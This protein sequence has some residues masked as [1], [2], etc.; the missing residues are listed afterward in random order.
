VDNH[1]NGDPKGRDPCQVAV[2]LRRKKVDLH[3]FRI[4]P[5][6]DAMWKLIK[7]AYDKGSHSAFGQPK[8]CLH[9]HE[10]PRGEGT[11]TER[12]VALVLDTINRSLS[13]SSI[14]SLTG[15]NWVGRAATASA[16]KSRFRPSLSAVLLG[17]EEAAGAGASAGAG[18]STAAPWGAQ[19]TAEIYTVHSAG[20]AVGADT[21]RMQKAPFAE[22]AMRAAFWMDPSGCGPLGGGRMVAKEGKRT[23]A[24]HNSKEALLG[25]LDSQLTAERLAE[26]WNRT[27]APRLGVP[28]SV[29][30]LPGFVMHFSERKRTDERWIAAERALPNNGADFRKFNNNGGFVDVADEAALANAFS[31]WTWQVTGGEAMVLD[32]Q[33]VNLPEGIVCTDAQVQCPD[34]TRYGRGN[35]GQQGIADFFAAHRCGPE[36]RQLRLRLPGEI[37]TASAAAEELETV[38]GAVLNGELVPEAVRIVSEERSQPRAAG[39]TTWQ[40]AGGQPIARPQ[41]VPDSDVFRCQ[42]STAPFCRKRGGIEFGLLWNRRH[43]CRACGVVVCSYCSEG[44]MALPFEEVGTTHRV[45]GHCMQRFTGS[46][47]APPPMGLPVLD[48]PV[49]QAAPQDAPAPVPVPVPVPVESQVASIPQSS[50]E[51][52]PTVPVGAVDVAGPA[53]QPMAASEP[54]YPTV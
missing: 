39:G 23:G 28:A 17:E 53:V 35:R 49:H 7:V 45:C 51:T 43:H 27:C 41:W 32:M 20:Q 30:F 16:A 21:V 10:A 33:G 48:A 42:V 40:A 1:P 11:A 50:T 25:D 36:C 47:V 18:S 31:H 37:R 5:A 8:W 24:A 3:A 12:F 54:L 14:R 13:A 9:T 4:E 46:F 6:T 29:K 2:Q 52:I 26:R 19:E 22:G 34:R 15:D 38:G 44:R